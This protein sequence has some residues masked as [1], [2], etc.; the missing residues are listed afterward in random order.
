MKSLESTYFWLVND[1]IVF[2][3]VISEAV[4]RM[5][6]A[7][8]AGEISEALAYLQQALESKQLT[9]DLGK[10]LIHIECARAANKLLIPSI[11]EK[12]IKLALSLLGS[13]ANRPTSYQHTEA[14]AIWMQGILLLFDPNN[15]TAISSIWGNSLQIF[16]QLAK[17]PNTY[18][19]DRIWYRERCEEM[20]QAIAEANSEI[21]PELSMFR[22]T[23]NV[24]S[25]SSIDIFSKIPAGG[26][27]LSSAAPF[28]TD[29]LRLQPS[30]DTFRLSEHEHHLYNLR[31]TRDQITLDHANNYCV[32]EVFGD[33]MNRIGI[34]HGNYVLMKI[35]DQAANGDMVASEIIPTDDRA[36]IRTYLQSE[37]SNQFIPQTSNPIH[38]EYRIDGQSDFTVNIHA[39]VLG[40]FKS[41]KPLTFPKFESQPES[42]TESQPPSFEQVFV[43]ESTDFYRAFPIYA[44]IPAG[45]PK[46]LPTKTRTYVKLNQFQIDDQ[47]YYLKSLRK[48]GHEVN[49]GKN[50]VIILKVTGDSMDMAG[51]NDGDYI[52]LNRDIMPESQDIV[53]AEIRDTDDKAT[54][55]RY[56]LQGGKA[57]L[58]PESSNEKHQ[59]LEF[60]HPRKDEDEPPFYIQGVAIGVLKPV[61][62]DVPTVNLPHRDPNT[63]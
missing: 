11:A 46:A 15:L 37:V 43:P 54:L 57:I 19:S 56:K 45:G 58:E 17:N 48:S 22:S 3:F 51:I 6:A 53:A 13:G 32:L 49:P 39:V 52:L 7:V 55:K 40:V 41:T 21:S 28:K 4:E 24:G 62:N 30:M 38:T 20:R 61:L 8:N 63:E 33:S 26:F 50:E 60:N 47:I 42:V 2:P 31:G 44:D 59:P 9:D 14:V 35:Q 18:K 36:I 10:A 23:L 29:E 16:E 5:H 27:T 25:L 34:E 12:Q 1:D